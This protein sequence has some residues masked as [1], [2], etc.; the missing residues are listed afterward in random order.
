ME[1]TRPW[2]PFRVPGLCGLVKTTCIMTV[3]SVTICLLILHFTAGLKVLPTGDQT[4]RTATTE[5]NNTTRQRARRDTFE[6]EPA[7]GLEGSTVTVQDGSNVSFSCNPYQK[8]CP[9]CEGR[10]EEYAGFYFCEH[11]CKW[12][13]VKAYAANFKWG[14]DKRFQVFAKHRLSNNRYGMTV[15]LT[16]VRLSDQGKYYCGLDL[17]GKDWYEEIDIIVNEAVPTL[18]PFV[19]PEVEREARDELAWME[20]GD[21]GKGQGNPEVQKAMMKCQGNKACA[22]AMLQKEELEIT[23]SCWLCLQM[24]H[25][26]KAVPLTVATANVT[27]CL[28]PQQMTDVLLAAAELEKGET[29]TKQPEDSCDNIRRYNNTDIAIPPLRVT[30]EKGDVCVCS[31][32]Q[33]LFTTGWSDCRV[34]VRSI[35]F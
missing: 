21:M 26:W 8:N 2:H 34:R 20:N 1:R 32:A 12:G 35:F 11:P 18:K 29:P 6:V 5:R 3:L 23:T 33:R 24:S 13:D 30:H 15:E 22:L 16:Q 28:I 14:K 9:G 27:K 10:S 19:T 17:E 4:N 25:A 31:D 7:R